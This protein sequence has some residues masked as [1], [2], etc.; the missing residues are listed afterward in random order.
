L[1]GMILNLMPCVLP[2][3]SLK[4]LSYVKQANNDRGR[5]FALGL[6]YCAGI[7]VF[8]GIIST[9]Y[10]TSG[11]AWGEHF[12]DPHVVLILAAIIMAFALSLFG[13]FAVFAPKVVN[14]LGVK[15]EESEGLHSAFFTGVLATILGTAC[16]GPF[17]SFALGAAREFSEFKGAMIFMCVG[18]GM[19][20]PF[21]ILSANPAWLKFVPKPGKW[22]GTFEAVMGFILLGTVVWIVNPIRTQLGDFGL[23]LALMFLLGVAVAVW[24]RG[25]AQFSTSTARRVQLNIAALVMI[26]GAWLVP[27]R[28]FATVDGLLLEAEADD[29]H[30]AIG[31]LVERIGGLKKILKDQLPPPSYPDDRID[32]FDYDPQFVELYVASGYT[33]FV[34]FTADW[35]ATCK[36]N[37]KTSIDIQATRDLMRELRVVPFEAD[38]TRRNPEMKKI[39]KSYGRLGVPLYLVF[40]PEKLDD[41]QILNDL[42]TPGAVEEA[43]RK[44]GPSQ[45]D[46]KVATATP[47][48]LVDSNARD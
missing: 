15:A 20:L 44:A 42:L 31:K 48:A 1:G 34:D 25:K 8:F 11:Q 12:Q 36:T 39:L 47:D 10:Y 43:L 46:T 21:L 13:V 14:Q 19:M 9:L 7:L 17:M 38:Y 24:L 45:L 4:I 27:F 26:V 3:I 30:Q 28:A 32:W 2:V 37:L 23:L 40:S 6:S 22:M 35:C 29:K 16:T 18:V 5:I 33:V 41:P